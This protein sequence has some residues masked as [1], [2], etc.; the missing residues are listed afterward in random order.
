MATRRA[1][2]QNLAQARL[3]DS[4]ILIAN[5]RYAAGY[6]LS[7]YAVELALKSCIARQFFENQ[8]PD[9]NFVNKVYT[10][11]IVDLIKLAGLQR[12][13][14]IM[15]DANA[16]FQAYWGIVGEWSVDSRYALTDPM[17]A[18]LLYQ[19]VSDPN[20][21]VFQWVRNHW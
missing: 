13:L 4:A 14:Q 15:Q 10:H 8:I 6:Y 16:N 19:A 9:K 3:E 2:L 11:Q 12:D 20:H 5:R 18:Q 17:S 21:G 1:D 7:G